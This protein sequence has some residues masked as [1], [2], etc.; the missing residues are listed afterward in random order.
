MLIHRT[1]V[2]LLA[3]NIERKGRGGDCDIQMK[4]QNRFTELEMGG[5]WVGALH[6]GGG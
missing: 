4:S 6:L 2:G 5:E 3:V 1:K